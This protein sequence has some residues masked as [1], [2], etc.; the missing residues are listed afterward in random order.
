MADIIALRPGK[1]I[2]KLKWLYLQI[3]K[4]I[5]IDFCYLSLSEKI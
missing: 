4:W 2:K 3:D 5:F 1:N